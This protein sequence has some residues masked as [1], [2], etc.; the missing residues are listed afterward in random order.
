[1]MIKEKF[2]LF[3]DDEVHKIP[4]KQILFSPWG[5]VA[6]NIKR[7]MLLGVLGAFVLT[8]FNF[9]S[10]NTVACIY[11]NYMESKAYCEENIY[12]QLIY[13]IIKLLLLASYVYLW[14]NYSK[15]VFTKGKFIKSVLKIGAFQFF[16]IILF[17][18]LPVLSFFL[19]QVRVPT[20]D[21][22]LEATYFI[23]VSV[24]FFGPFLF[25]RLALIWAI[26]SEGKEIPSL[27]EIWSHGK[28]NTL[29][30][31][32]G[33]LTIL[34]IGM[35]LFLKFYGS[36]AYLVQEGSRVELLVAELMYNFLMLLMFTLFVNNALVQMHVLR[37]L[38]ANK[39][40]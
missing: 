26:W 17:L 40:N 24:G 3:Q 30:M 18:M 32:T 10:G 8:I 28:G 9:A 7:F 25:A 33:Y 4:L 1:M 19:L 23:I 16:G 15:E 27:K 11:A 21:W 6:E 38:K 29:R 5:L 31:T 37:E 36:A 20:P 2:K 13:F 14:V 12:L 34:F 35:Y 39:E 22:R